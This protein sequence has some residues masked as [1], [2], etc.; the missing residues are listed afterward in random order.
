MNLKPNQIAVSEQTQYA[1]CGTLRLYKG[2]IIKIIDWDPDQWN[3]IAVY[4]SLKREK[5]NKMTYVSIDT[6]RPAS[7]DE[8]DAYYNGIRNINQL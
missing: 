8:I 2:E 7:L 1:S 4:R 5:L 3:E 6:L